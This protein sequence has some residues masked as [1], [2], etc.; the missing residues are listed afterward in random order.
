MKQRTV[1]AALHKAA[2]RS[3]RHP[4]SPTSGHPAAAGRNQV[5]LAFIRAEEYK[6]AA[7]QFRLIGDEATEVPMAVLR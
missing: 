4:A 5:G 7:Q 1:V 6:A 3:V 2:D